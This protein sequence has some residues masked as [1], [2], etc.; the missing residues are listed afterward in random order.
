MNKPMTRRG[1]LLGVLAWLLLMTL[2]LFAL[3][4]AMRGEVGWR[5]G[6]FVEDRVWL[7]HLDNEP[8]G[9]RASG[10][11]YSATRL[12]A[13]P[14]AGPHAICARTRV[15]FFLWRGASEPADYCECFRLAPGGSYEALGSCP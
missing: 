7:V 8:G 6:A 11:A 9:E 5:R 15:Y 3:V 12:A 1:C 2:P 10:L 13:R 4:L 14:A